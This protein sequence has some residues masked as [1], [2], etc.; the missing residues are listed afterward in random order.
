[1]TSK[2]SGNFR[3]FYVSCK[4]CSNNVNMKVTK[5]DQITRTCN[6]FEVLDCWC[7]KTSLFNT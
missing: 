7:V 4:L 2:R 6:D 3:V 1:M 5:C